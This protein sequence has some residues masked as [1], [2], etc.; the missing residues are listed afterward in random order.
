MI[1]I[2]VW[3]SS[4]SLD[5]RAQA[6]SPVQI[7]NYIKAHW[8]ADQ[9]PPLPPSKIS[10]ELT[11]GSGNNHGSIGYS[12]LAP[13]SNPWR[14]IK[15]F[16]KQW[17][18]ETLQAVVPIGQEGGT[19]I[20]VVLQAESI[21]DESMTDEKNRPRNRI[22][23]NNSKHWRYHNIRVWT[24]NELELNG[25]KELA[26][27]KMDEV[28]AAKGC[29]SGATHLLSAKSHAS[30]EEEEE[31]SDDDYWGQYGDE[32]DSRSDESSTAKDSQS[33]KNPKTPKTPRAFNDRQF[34]CE[35][36]MDEDEEE[37][38]LKYNEQELKKTENQARA[39]SMS[40]SY[41]DDEPAIIQDG[42]EDGDLQ[43]LR[44]GTTGSSTRILASLDTSSHL[45][46]KAPLSPGQVDPNMLSS[47]LQMLVKE[48][49]PQPSI[50]EN[51]ANHGQT[52]E[53]PNDLERTFA[54][55]GDIRDERANKDLWE[56]IDQT[57]APAPLA[58]LSTKAETDQAPSTNGI[59]TSKP[60]ST[61]NLK[62]TTS[63][64]M[65]D[66]YLATPSTDDSHS[67][68]EIIT[69][70]SVIDHLAS[71]SKVTDSLTLIVRDATLAGLSKDDVFELLTNVK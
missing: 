47:I 3:D 6:W 29:H 36:P 57:A 33:T 21:D 63:L 43:A 8:S 42:V 52:E 68:S 55:Q 32:D 70:G 48:G 44:E 14:S 60:D 34:S 56:Q 65:T 38:W 31:D 67:P 25:W 54:Q 58:P 71:R 62:P 11:N 1:D 19:I 2:C 49:F 5:S 10:S 16:T 4:S 40:E 18:T 7:N 59:I 53:L 30:E 28:P 26:D 27:P 12:S 20:G 51:E 69:P 35:T 41:H 61:E 45:V 37:Y 64:L 13:Q 15:V 24:E 9:L 22:G 39:R 66:H 23:S 46:E 50:H 17:D